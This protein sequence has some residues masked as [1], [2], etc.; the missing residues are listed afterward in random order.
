MKLKRL[1]PFVFVA[2]VVLA[3]LPPQV[4]SNGGRVAAQGGTPDPTGVSVVIEGVVQFISGNTWI[5]DNITV[6]VTTSTSI[7]GY[8]VVGSIVKIVG[9][10]GDDGKVVVVTVAL[11]PATPAATEV[12]GTEAPTPAATKAAT[13]VPF[14]LIIIEGPVEAVIVNTSTVIV[15]YG[16]H[17]RL[18]DDDPLK[19][20]IKVGDWVHL[21]GRFDR[22]DDDQIIIVAVV[23]V[24]IIEPA[25][26]VIIPVGGGGGNGHHGDDDD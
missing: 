1:L 23:V 9:T 22:D 14:T 12:E 3:A 6:N 8:P 13:G 2:L 7:T 19:L 15:V 10:R 24:V 26:V 21:R 20:K 5:V 16:Q 17:I 18:R 4:G 25:P 11:T